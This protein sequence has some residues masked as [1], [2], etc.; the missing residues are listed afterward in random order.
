MTLATDTDNLLST[1]G[2]QMYIVRNT[3]TY[4][5]IGE[6]GDA[7]T[8]LSTPNADIQRISGN[9]PARDLGQGRFMTHRIFLPDNTD[10]KQG[11]RLRTSDWTAGRAEYFVESVL[12]D[13][14]HVELRASMARTIINFML[15]E[16]GELLTL[17]DETALQLENYG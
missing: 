12:S 6:G 13:E 8:I 1:W 4:G 9:N 11:D 16:T 7:F 10:V 2:E 14:G 17:E 3:P 5:N 15:V